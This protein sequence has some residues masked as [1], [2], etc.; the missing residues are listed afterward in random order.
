MPMPDGFKE[1]LYPRLHEIAEVFETPFHIYDEQGI[2]ETC[3]RLHFAFERQDIDF[4]E[5]FAVK[6]NPNPRIMKIF[7]KWGW[8]FDCS[9][10]PEL[11]LARMIGTRPE[12]IMFTSNNTT[13]EE[14]KIALVEGGSILNLDDISLISKV[15]KMPKLICFR[16][17]PGE[18]RSGNSIIG[19]PV[20][21]KYGVAHDQ[22][23]DA[24]KMA[25]KRGAEKFGIHTMICS[26]ELNYKYMVETVQMLCE[27]MEMISSKLSIKFEFMNMGG[28]LGIPYEPGQEEIPV[29]A[30]AEEIGDCLRK[31]RSR[32]DYVPDLYLESGRYMTGPHGVLVTQAINHK[33]TY[34]KWV[35]VDT[36]MASLM[37]PGIYWPDGGYHHIDV[38]GPGGVKDNRK[39]ENVSVVGPLCENMDQCQKTVSSRD[40][41]R[42]SVGHPGYGRPRPCYGL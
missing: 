25:I 1:R 12:N 28:G 16:Y 30:M 31:F 33:D 38:F 5:F 3:Q 18:R 9:S 14:F 19:D 6:A 21:A 2:M 10:S 32:N 26:N 23:V 35:G 37:R 13:R 40:Q 20:N 11:V 15:P 27:V 42:R 41:G 29:E 24:Y 8:G 39:T 36:S 34:Q 4:K 7:H 22:I 17:N